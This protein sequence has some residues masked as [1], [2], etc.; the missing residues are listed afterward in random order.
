MTIDSFRGEYRF[1]SNFEPSAVALD[2]WEY[3]TVEHAYQAAKTLNLDER[4]EIRDAPSPG[5]AK[6]LGRLATMR[7]DFETTKVAI[8]SDLVRQKFERHQE[9]RAKL[10]A[11]EDHHLIEGNTWGDKYWGVCNGRGLNYLG[12]VLMSVRE[13]LRKETAQ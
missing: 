4:T 8:M 1:L 5:K 9:L 13:A 12:R 3:P 7:P 2:G 10:L 11:T 6:V